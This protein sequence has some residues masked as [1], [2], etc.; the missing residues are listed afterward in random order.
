MKKILC[1]LFIMSSLNTFATLTEDEKEIIITEID[2]TCGDVWCESDYN[3]SFEELEETPDSVILKY[4]Q[5]ENF[6][7]RIERISKTCLIKGYTKFS[8]MIDSTD[9]HDRKLHSLTEDFYLAV[10]DCF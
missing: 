8:Q 4:T 5:I 3:Y 1:S 7:D 6:D 10:N 2:N 9:L